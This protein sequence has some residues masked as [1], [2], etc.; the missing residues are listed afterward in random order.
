MWHDATS[1]IDDFWPKLCRAV[2]IGIE[3]DEY[4]TAVFD[5]GLSKLEIPPK[6][7][8]FVKNLARRTRMGD[9]TSV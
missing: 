5:L 7:L 9:P 1:T 4:P 2:I 3:Q 8:V 6:L